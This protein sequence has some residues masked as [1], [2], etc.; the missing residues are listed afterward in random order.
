MFRHGLFLL[1]TIARDAKAT[2]EQL[3]PYSDLTLHK[4]LSEGFLHPGVCS[5]V[6]L[7]FETCPLS[8]LE[9][10]NRDILVTNTCHYLP[11][12][13]I[14]VFFAKRLLGQAFL[15]HEKTLKLQ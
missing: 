2:K 3:A 10:T 12:D 7:Y 1:N 6:E 14:S 11:S 5:L 8:I 13:A 9:A 15:D 4:Y